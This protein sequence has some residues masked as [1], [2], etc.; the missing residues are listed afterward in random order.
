[1]M[2]VMMAMPPMV[3]AVWIAAIVMNIGTSAIARAGVP[4]VAA[5]VAIAVVVVAAAAMS[6]VDPIGAGMRVAGGQRRKRDTYRN[7][8]WRKA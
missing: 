1:M 3:A 6:N 4:V 7:Q 2:V 8:V 5:A